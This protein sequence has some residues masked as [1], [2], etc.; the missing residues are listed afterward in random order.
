MY[1]M[2][3]AIGSIAV[4]VVIWCAAGHRS[5]DIAMIGVVVVFIEYINKFFI[6]VRD[7]SRSTPSCRA[8][9]P[10]ASGSSSCS[11]PRSPTA[12][13]PRDARRDAVDARRRPLAATPDAPGDRARRRPLQ[14]RRRAGA[15][16][17]RRARP[18][19]RD[20]RRRRRD[21][22]R[23]VDRDQAADPPLRARARRDPARRRRHPRH[24]ARRAARA[25]SPSSRRT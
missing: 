3:E 8:R 17:R 10:R 5:E 4:G 23:Q 20:G 18:A 1:A 7:L 16:R 12:A 19:R 24:P 21:R 6:P 13:T 25:G 9:W 14:L 2:V 15:A 11:T 22:L